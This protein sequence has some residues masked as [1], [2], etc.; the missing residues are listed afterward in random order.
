MITVDQQFDR[1]R[2]I[3]FQKAKR[4]VPLSGLILVGGAGDSRSA[5]SGEHA[6]AVVVID[7]MQFAGAIP[8]ALELEFN[9][10]GISRITVVPRLIQ[11]Q[12]VGISFGVFDFQTVAVRTGAVHTD[13]AQCRIRAPGEDHAGSARRHADLDLTVRRQHV[14]RRNRQ[15]GGDFSGTPPSV[16][17]D[18]GFFLGAAERAELIVPL[19]QE[20]ADLHVAP[21]DRCKSQNIVLE[22]KSVLDRRAVRDDKTLEPRAV[23]FLKARFDIIVGCFRIF[24]GL[25]DDLVMLQFFPVDTLRVVQPQRN[26]CGLAVRQERSFIVGTNERLFPAADG[27]ER[28]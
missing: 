27:A 13:A 8:A 5:E 2:N 1:L 20:H 7:D 15:G 22:R 19:G 4:I 9:T 23:C 25:Q 6:A 28:R 16:F 14:F 11:R 24:H 18:N 10:I 3:V 17:H 12:R 21:A 26:L